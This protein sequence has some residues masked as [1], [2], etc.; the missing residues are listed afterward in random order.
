M[1]TLLI[2]RFRR[3]LRQFERLNSYQL[4]A[5]CTEVTFAQCL[6]LL[7]VDEAVQP[8]MGRLAAT[9]RLDNSTLSRTIEGL[10]RKA[11]VQRRPDD[12][13]RR[14]VLIALTATGKRVC[15]AIHRHNDACV[16]Q[17]FDNIPPS[18]HATVIRNFET[19]V[20]AFLDCEA[21]TTPLGGRTGRRATSGQQARAR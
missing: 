21:K 13:D 2:R 16:L 9:L 3:A 11:M 4:K 8:S 14:T 15:R 17:L 19:L 18:R 12:T 1:N 20:Q 5:C 6:V 7:E 10:V